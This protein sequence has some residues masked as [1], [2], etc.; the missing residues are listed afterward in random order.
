MGAGRVGG[1]RWQAGIRAAHGARRSARCGAMPG[2]VGGGACMGRGGVAERRGPTDQ[3]PRAA[4]RASAA[5][6]V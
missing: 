6:R 1:M 3:G 4:G 5:D 2:A